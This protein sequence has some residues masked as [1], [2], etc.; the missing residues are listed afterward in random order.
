MRV[1]PSSVL[2]LAVISIELRKKMAIFLE[3]MAKNFQKMAVFL[4]KMAIF[5]SC[6][7]SMALLLASNGS[8]A[9]IE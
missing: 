4:R 9:R 6:S 2:S 1:W 7:Y 3:K 5:S 8:V